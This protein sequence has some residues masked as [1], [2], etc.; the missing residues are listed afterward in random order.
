MARGNRGGHENASSPDG[1]TSIQTDGPYD[2][3]WKRQKQIFDAE[4]KGQREVIN[5]IGLGNIGS[6]AG[7]ALAR[8]GL[9]N[10]T[11]WDGDIVEAHNLSS[12]SYDMMD[13]G[14]GKT[15]ATLSHMESINPNVDVMLMEHYKGQVPLTGIVIVAVDSIEARKEILDHIKKS[16]V[17]PSLL[18]DGRLG[19]PQLEIY[20]YKSNEIEDWEKKMYEGTSSDPCGA[21]YISYMSMLIGALIANQVK[22]Y[23]NEEDLNRNVIFHMDSLEIIN[24]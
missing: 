19:G 20:T 18:I 22:R 15:T 12:Q 2:I 14:H 7:V 6:Q 4:D 24:T 3:S 13:I 8:M 1:N 21:R 10:Y 9:Q 17:K 11:L 5:I 23:L 16:K